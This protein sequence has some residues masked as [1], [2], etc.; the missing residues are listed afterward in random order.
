MFRSKLPLLTGA[1]L[2][3]AALTTVS[4]VQPAAAKRHRYAAR[5][6]LVPA[7]QRADYRGAPGF[8]GGGPGPVLPA[9]ID[10]AIGPPGGDTALFAGLAPPPSNGG[11]L[12][13]GGFLGT[14]ALPQTGV[15]TGVPIIGA[16]G[17]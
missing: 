2:A 10:P 5:V 9:L 8:A 13:G 7:H 14:G 17:F 11:L 3:F 6:R 1:T 16:F 4:C 12:G 15:L